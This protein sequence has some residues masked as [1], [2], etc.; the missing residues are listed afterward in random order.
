M[1]LKT[2]TA[3][4][5]A[6]K[7]KAHAAW[8]KDNA[9]GVRLN[10]SYS[11]LSGSDLRYSDLRYSNLSYSD[12][13]YSNLSGSDLRYSDLRY[14]NL[15]YSDLRYSNL[16]GSDL[17]VPVVQHIDAAILAAVES[18]G[19]LNMSDWHKCETTHCRAG[20]AITLAGAPG[21]ELE[22]AVGP[23]VAGAL[24]YAASRPTLP[25]PNF[26]ASDKDAMASIIA[27][28]AAATA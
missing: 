3:D 11:D 22:K 23:A 24:I 6:A 17:R 18:G 21:A 19:K 10:L 15:R 28:A 8:L 27:D 12:L 9:E 25:V 5:I 13:R 2:W 20:W 14:S 16:S 4:E 7:I 26:Y 1:A